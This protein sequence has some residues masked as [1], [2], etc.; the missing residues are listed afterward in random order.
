MEKLSPKATPLAWYACPCGFTRLSRANAQEVE[1]EPCRARETH[2]RGRE[3][4]RGLC[5]EA[6]ARRHRIDEYLRRLPSGLI[7]D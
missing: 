2:E 5:N 1:C 6:L 4:L 7:P 3:W